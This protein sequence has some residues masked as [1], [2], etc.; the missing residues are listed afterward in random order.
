MGKYRPFDSSRGSWLLPGGVCV[1][2]CVCVIHRSEFG[3]ETRGGLFWGGEGGAEPGE[4]SFLA[5]PGKEMGK[6]QVL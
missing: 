5:G 4:S 3:L 1:C 6:S 2:V